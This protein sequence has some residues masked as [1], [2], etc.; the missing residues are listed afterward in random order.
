MLISG[1]K[2]K[3]TQKEQELLSGMVGRPVRPTTVADYN[4]CLQFVKDDADPLVPE[5]R[6]LAAIADGMM[7]RGGGTS[8]VG[9]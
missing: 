6:L 5:E 1:D 3:L 8:A 4:A 9:D 2:I 7:V